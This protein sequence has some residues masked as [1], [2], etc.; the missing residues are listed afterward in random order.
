MTNVKNLAWVV[1]LGG[2]WACSGGGGATSDAG[3]DAI[4]DAVSDAGPIGCVDSSSPSTTSFSLS[5]WPTFTAIT[6]TDLT[7]QADVTTVTGLGSPAGVLVTKDGGWVMTTAGGVLDVLKRSGTTLTLDHTITMPTN[8]TAFGIAASPDGTM[9]A[10]T[11]SDELGLYDLTKVESNAPDALIAY[12]PTHSAMRTTIDVTFTLDS[13]Y[14]FAALEYDHSVAVVNAQ[15]QTY[16]GAIPIAGDAVTGVALSPDGSKLYV[17]TEESDQFAAANPMPA[18]DQVV[19]SITVVDVAT[20]ITSPTTSVVGAAFVGRAPVRTIVSAD[21]TRLWVSVRGSNAVIELDATNLLSTT[22]EPRLATVT[23]GPAPVG[24]AFAGPTRIAVANSNRFLEPTMN[25]TVMWLDANA[26]AVLGQ[27]G[28]GAF[29]REMDD[30][31]SALFVSNYDSSSIS[32]ID[33]MSLP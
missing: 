5:T 6:A 28:V 15:T 23:V 16:V 18:Q 1:G 13:Q 14:A 17:T 25:Q 31:V 10:V 27:I 30:D 4:T 9:I 20:A 33:L 21:G 24:L 3:S 29:P 2:L 8:E 26:A 12:V 22:C 32:G 11:L 19:G 7:S